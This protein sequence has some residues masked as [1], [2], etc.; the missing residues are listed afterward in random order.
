MTLHLALLALAPASA[1]DQAI[2]FT[3]APIQ[4]VVAHD[5]AGL[6]KL[7]IDPDEL[8]LPDETAAAATIALLAD[9]AVEGGGCV[10]MTHDAAQVVTEALACDGGSVTFERN[11]L[12]GALDPQIPETGDLA[13]QDGCA[14]AEGCSKVWPKPSEGVVVEL[15]TDGGWNVGVRVKGR[16]VTLDDLAGAYDDLT[17][18]DDPNEDIMVAF[19]NGWLTPVEI[20]PADPG[21]DD[22]SDLQSVVES[23]ISVLSDFFSGDDDDG[24]GDPADPGTDQT[25]SP[26]GD[27]AVP[28]ECADAVADGLPTH[29]GGDIDPSPLDPSEGDVYLGCF[30][31]A[32]LVDQISTCFDDRLANPGPDGGSLC[33]DDEPLLT[34]PLLTRN[35]LVIDP[36]PVGEVPEGA[37]PDLP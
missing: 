13:A 25:P 23:V 11:P 9:H 29:D 20:V 27:G 6:H 7:Y 18:W 2:T 35:D 32:D 26:L 10:A 5:H 37:G 21:T 16:Q 3:Y 19:E 8:A 34:V 14:N 31:G 17:T 22:V 15:D 33:A 12:A 30:P 36:A 28:V 1:Q 4:S 24:T